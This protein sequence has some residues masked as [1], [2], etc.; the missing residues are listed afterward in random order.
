MDQGSG[1]DRGLIRVWVWFGLD[2]FKFGFSLAKMY[3]GLD[4]ILIRRKFGICLLSFWFV[5]V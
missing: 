3:Q 2:R 5:M 4:L 1:W